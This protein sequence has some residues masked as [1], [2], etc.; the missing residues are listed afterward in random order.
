MRIPPEELFIMRLKGTLPSNRLPAYEWVRNKTIEEC[1]EG[2]K[3]LS[4]STLDVPRMPG[5]SGGSRKRRNSE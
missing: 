2:L 5:N 1:L 3:K 4:G